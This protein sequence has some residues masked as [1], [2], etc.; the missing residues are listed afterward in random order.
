LLLLHEWI[1]L[2]D[3]LARAAISPGFRQLRAGLRNDVARSPGQGLCDFDG[4]F[5]PHLEL[6]QLPPAQSCA[7]QQIDD[8]PHLV[9]AMDNPGG[10][11][12]RTG[13]GGTEVDASQAG[14][15]GERLEQRAI[16]IAHSHHYPAHLAGER[17]MTFAGEESSEIGTQ[18][19]LGK[20]N[21][22][23]LTLGGVYIT[24][25]RTNLVVCEGK[26]RR[27]GFVD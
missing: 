4:S 23:R 2:C 6:A 14:R 17:K 10:C 18:G 22:L 27:P 20:N 25:Q 12:T 26:A 3:G 15:G 1:S 5:T 11:R 9:A 8:R 13:V 16:V 7:P 21:Y 19:I 24:S